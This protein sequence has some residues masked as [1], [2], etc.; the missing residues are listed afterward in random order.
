MHSAM[1]VVP[2]QGAEQRGH[3][4]ISVCLVQLKNT[5]FKRWG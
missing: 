4:G 1:S 5:Y 3:L 2:T